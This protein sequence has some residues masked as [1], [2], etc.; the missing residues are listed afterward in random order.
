MAPTAMKIKMRSRCALLLAA[1]AACLLAC[2]PS[3][4]A[5]RLPPTPILGL[6]Q[7]WGVVTA[8]YARVKTDPSSMAQEVTYLRRGALVEIFARAYGRD[9]VDEEEGYWYG[10]RVDGKSGWIFSGYLGVYDRK[11]QAQ[12]AG[13]DLQ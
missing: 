11:E 10:V 9:V 1:M 12:R 7:R 5:P 2:D 13:A 6:S 8:A 4:R 3:R